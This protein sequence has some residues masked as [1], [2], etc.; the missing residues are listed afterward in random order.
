MMQS[1]LFMS[2]F[3][4][5]RGG[6]HATGFSRFILAG[7]VLCTGAFSGDLPV[8]NFSTACHADGAAVLFSNRNASISL[9]QDDQIYLASGDRVLHCDRDGSHPVLGKTGPALTGAT[10]NKAG[11]LAAAHAHFARNVT[12]YSRDYI[13]L[14]RFTRLGDYNFTAPAGIEAGPSG[15]FY[16]LD[17]GRDQIIRF[18][19]DGIRAQIYQIP[20]EEYSDQRYGYLTRFRVCEQTHAL[21]VV[22]W[23]NI[24]CFSIDSNE[25]R[26]TPKLKWELKQPQTA[27]N[28]SYGYGGISVDE[29]GVLY[30]IAPLGEESLT[31]YDTNGN[32][33]KKLPLQVGDHKFVDPARVLGLVVSRGE[34][35]IRRQHDSEMFLRFNLKTGEL[36]TVVTLPSNLEP[37]VAAPVQATPTP[38]A[39]VKSTLGLPPGR[40]ILRV[41]FI[42]NSQVSCVRDI[43]DMVEDIARSNPSKAAPIVVSDEVVIG[44][45]GLEGYWKDGLAQ[46]KIASGGWDYVV[47]NDIVY[48]FG[49]TSHDKFMEYAAKFDGEIKRVHAKTLV[50]STADI[51]KKR[52]QHA[53]MYN[54]AL[55]FARAHG[56]RVAGAG[57]A[58]LKVWEQKPDLE[59]HYTDHAHPNAL[60]CYL[61]ALVLYAALTDSN[62]TNPTISTCDAASAE[63]AALLQRAAWQQYQEDRANE[64]SKEVVTAK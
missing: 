33:L 10:A 56:D 39:P 26:F 40:K 60:G 58:W 34:A 41:L 18:H 7:L 50:F 46:R 27:M 59:L 9:G 52:E 64:K 23:Q 3:C 62:P 42:G 48:S 24:R 28:L 57:M 43:P 2:E 17:Q 61:N 22:N 36:L 4:S 13:P 49:I 14:G 5:R 11:L 12:L 25:F 35:F 55:E 8:L 31:S 37:I 21:Y 32:L 45:T 16:V 51:D 47:F 1:V 38:I 19:P 30:I 29:N 63:Q 20:H 53:L 54:D 15:D 6:A 44:G